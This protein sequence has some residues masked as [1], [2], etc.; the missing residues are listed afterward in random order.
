M[1]K[2]VTSRIYDY[3]NS[4][5]S[6]ELEDEAGKLSSTDFNSV[7]SKLV[8]AAKGSVALLPIDADEII[9]IL[10]KTININKLRT[11]REKI[12]QNIVDLLGSTPESCDME[13]LH[14]L[15]TNYARLEDF[16]NEAIEAN[17]LLS[18]GLLNKKLQSEV[19]T[20]FHLVGFNLCR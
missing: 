13:L 18:V 20:T 19:R 3:E 7:F 2:T 15:T 1:K 4:E 6:A 11:P 5:I 17:R 10:C 9:S 16:S 14:Y 8:Q 12:T